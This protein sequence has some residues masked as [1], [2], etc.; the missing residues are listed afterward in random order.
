[1][2]GAVQWTI[3]QFYGQLQALKSQID[4]ADAA[5]KANATQLGN[6]YRKAQAAYDPARDAYIAP[7]IHR[8]TVLRL[9]YL[10]PVRSKFNEAV[11][12]TSKLLRSA[13]YSTPGLSDVG[14]LPAVPVVAISAVLLGL[15]AVAIVWRLTQAQ[16]Q[17][18]ATVAA[19]FQ[20]P[21]TTAEQKVAL[22]KQ[23]QEQM[24][25]EDRRNPPL[26]GFK[27]DDLIP[28]AAIVAAVVLGPRILD[29]IGSRRRA[30]A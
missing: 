6:M 2:A 19:I 27:F 29:M 10:A 24:K 12:A 5:L 1:M 23:M 15:S 11:N 22:S 14:V 20:D 18:T 17:R 8:N 16:I 21:H 26:G 25:D 28:L 4:Q 9:T 3:D 7:L 13:G 30:V